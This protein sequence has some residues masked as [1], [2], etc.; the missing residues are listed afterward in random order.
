LAQKIEQGDQKAVQKL[1]EANLNFVITIAKH[2]QHMGIPLEDLICEGNIGLVFAAR[3]FD[4]GRGMKF[5]TY[6]VWWIRRMILQALNERSRLVRLPKYKIRELREFKKK[7]N[8]KMNNL[9][10]EPNVSEM[11]ESLGLSRSNIED[12]MRCDLKEV[13]LDAEDPNDGFSLSDQ[14]TAENADMEENFLKWETMEKVRSAMSVLPKRERFILRSRYGFEGET[15]TLE[16]IGDEIGLTKER[17]RQ[18]EVQAKERLRRYLL[19]QKMHLMM[20]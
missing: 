5:I 16:D 12:L 13:S 10:R 7:Y 19:E 4:S 3:R 2:Y 11:E 14:V 15:R 9:S 6:A 17:V 8:E 1:V 18:I 20:A